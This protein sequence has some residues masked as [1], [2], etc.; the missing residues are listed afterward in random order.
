MGYT[1]YCSLCGGTSLVSDLEYHHDEQRLKLEPK[2]LEFHS[3]IYVLTH[4]KLEGVDKTPGLRDSWGGDVED[5]EDQEIKY[6]LTE[7]A[8]DYFE[9]FY[10][11][12]GFYDDCER[13]YGILIHSVCYDLI[14]RFYDIRMRPH[15]SL[16][17]QPLCDHDILE[18]LKFVQNDMNGSTVLMD[19]DIRMTMGQD[20]DYY[21]DC[22]WFVCSP[23]VNLTSLPTLPRTMNSTAG[24]IFLLLPAVILDTVFS[25]L[26]LNDFDNL[27]GV[28][29]AMNHSVQSSREWQTQCQHYL[30]VDILPECSPIKSRLIDWNRA[31]ADNGNL[32]NPH[33]IGLIVDRLFGC[34]PQIFNILNNNS[35]SYENTS[36][37]AELLA[38]L[39]I[40]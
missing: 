28:S 13:I 40:D 11:E 31:I 18:A 24:N 27:R 5:A 38:N 37:R 14:H 33:R 21:P 36:L 19:A 10:Q 3:R 35:F 15:Q 26:D 2:D 7:N 16:P 29:R 39:E 4:C 20:F 32:R 30:F 25:Y 12:D 9:G 22:D 23:M 8:T 6:V 34:I 17:Q 1:T